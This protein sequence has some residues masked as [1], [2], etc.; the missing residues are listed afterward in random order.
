MRLITTITGHIGLFL[1]TV[2]FA[3]LVFMFALVE[4]KGRWWWHWARMWG[5]TIYWGSFSNIR[6]A[7]FDQIQWDQPAILMANHESYLDVPAIIASSP[8]P[9]RFVARK[10][11]FKTP[12]MGQAMWV[13][14]QIPVDRSN[15]Q[16]AIESLSK[17]AKRIA[18]GRTV[19][20]FPEGT[21]SDDG[22]LGSFKKGGFML[23]LESGAPIIPVGLSGTRE[24]VP[25]GS[26]M[27]RSTRVG[28]VV[29]QPIATEGL[30]IE[31]REQLMERVR[32]QIQNA[33]EKASA[34]R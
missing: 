9:L 16:Q 28:I 32:N 27:F 21:R 12:I 3:S 22:A 30:T 2:V 20:V 11:V 4:R 15:R 13:T 31:D 18:H 10:E 14:G 6:S 7:G 26:W 29:G 33:R 1:A 23:A 19:L 25:K 8:V 34:L 17:A 24:L 5:R